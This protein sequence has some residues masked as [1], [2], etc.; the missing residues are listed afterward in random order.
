MS[1]AIAVPT[2]GA[3][4]KFAVDTA[5]PFMEEV[6]DTTSRLAVKIDQEPRFNILLRIS[7]GADHKAKQSLKNPESSPV[8][9][10]E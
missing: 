8:G 9:A 1:V 7:L 10:M 6:G 5:L 3:S 4:G 2:K